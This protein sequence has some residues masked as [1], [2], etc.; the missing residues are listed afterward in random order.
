M[1]NAKNIL[2]TAVYGLNDAKMQIMQMLGQLLTNPQAIGTAIAIHG[3]MGTGKTSIVKEGI[4]K[5]LNRPFAFIALG[6][7]T[8]SS[9][10]EG[11][12]Y[13][14]EGS[15]WGKIVQ[16]LIDSKC[17]NPVIYFDELD[18]IS[19]TPKGEEI[20]GIL[21]HLTDTAQNSQFHDKYYAEVDFDL[22]K[23]LFIFSYND[24]TK[25]NPILRDRMYRIM[26]KGYDKKQK[27]VICNN[28]LLPKIR[29]Q[30]KFVEGDIVIPDDSLQYI[31]ETH[32]NGEDG[33]RNMKRCL[34]I[35]HTKLNLYR[36]MKPGSS[37]FDEQKALI[38]EFPFT[39]TKDI[40]DKLI[41]KERND[42]MAIRGMY[43]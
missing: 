8:D 38:V 41:T 1:E 37:L 30:V 3:P 14:Y 16:I 43:V 31:M 33:V 26:T 24:E 5:I 4:S 17:M 9:F 21:T 12:S 22:S 39:V 19:E 25:I 13:T 36:L 28:H 35:I 11:H 29:E 40:V 34:E 6:G 23:C 10:L 20:A 42:N 32:C 27:T 7:A 15:T 18:K 2:D